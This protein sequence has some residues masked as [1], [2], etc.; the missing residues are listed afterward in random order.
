MQV[1]SEQHSI[2]HTVNHT[3]HITGPSNYIGTVPSLI[4]WL[5]SISWYVNQ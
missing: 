3:F 1:T 2:G 4:Q 5:I